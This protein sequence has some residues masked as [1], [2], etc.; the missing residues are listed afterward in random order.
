MSRITLRAW[1]GNDLPILRLTVGDAK[2]MQHLGGAETEEQIVARHERF[3]NASEAGGMFTIHVDGRPDAAGTIGFWE[4]EWQG[5]LVYETGWMVLPQYARRG[6]ASQAART[7]IRYAKMERRHRFLHAYPSA[8]NLPSNA[9]CRNAGF[10]MA[11]EY[12]F[13]Y[14][15]GHFMLCNDWVIDLFPEP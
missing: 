2:M 9:V 7:I 15:K 3:L 14:P 13:E 6:V 4:R 1:T 10:H 5:E 8:D 12:T 11:G